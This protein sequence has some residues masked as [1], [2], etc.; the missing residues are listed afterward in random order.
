M[1]QPR[2]RDCQARRPAHAA[3]QG[4]GRRDDRKLGQGSQ[5]E[6]AEA[7][8]CGARQLAEGDADLRRRLPHPRQARD[9]LCGDRQGVQGD[10]GDR[11]FGPVDDLEHGPRRDARAAEPRRPGRADDVL[12]RGAQGVARRT[13]ARRLRHAR[14]REL[15]EA[16]PLVDGHAGG[17]GQARLPASPLLHPRRGGVQ[18]GAAR[19]AGV[20]RGTRAPV[21]ER[22]RATRLGSG[23][24]E[25]ATAHLGVLVT[26]SCPARRPARRPCVEYQE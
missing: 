13:R 20:L 4:R 24:P 18:N 2:R 19:G 22:W 14:R 15:D 1:R 9:G 8:L 3:A 16:H 5:L 11:H 26:S 17:Q 10:G 23:A 6:R 12:G 7:D 25:P 21:P